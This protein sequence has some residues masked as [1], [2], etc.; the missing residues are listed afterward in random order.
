MRS[1]TMQPSVPVQR[2]SVGAGTGCQR[3]LAL[4]LLSLMPQVKV[5]ADKIAYSAAISACEK[6]C[7]RELALNLLSLMPQAKVVADKITYNAMLDAV[8]DKS[9]GSV[10]S[11]RR[12]IMP[13]MQLDRT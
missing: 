10:L 11:S 3:E 13:S 7:Q 12:S 6:G 4:N 5:V 1:L 9:S 2:R 8:S